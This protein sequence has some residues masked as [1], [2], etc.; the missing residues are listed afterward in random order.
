MSIVACFIR[1]G[2]IAINRLGWEIL[3]YKNLEVAN[4]LIEHIMPVN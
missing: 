1:R 4:N 3:T 2:P